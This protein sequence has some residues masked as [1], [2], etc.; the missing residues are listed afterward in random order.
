MPL[1]LRAVKE[2]GAPMQSADRY[3]PSLQARE[4]MIKEDQMAIPSNP[5]LDESVYSIFATRRAL[6]RPAKRP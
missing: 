1:Q 6:S 4:K 3:L 2:L 5:V